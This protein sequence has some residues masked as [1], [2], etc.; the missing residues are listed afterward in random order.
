SNDNGGSVAVVDRAGNKQ[1]L[2]GKY[3]A[4]AGLAWSPKGDEVWF[5]AA[6]TGAR[7]DLRAVTMSGRE[8]VL[9]A[10]SVSVLL[11]DV[12]KDGRV[13]IANTEDRMKLMFR[14]PTDKVERE[15]SWLDWSLLNSLSPDGKYVAFSEAGEG[16]GASYAAY[17]RETNGAPAVLLGKGVGPILSP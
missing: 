14:G 12:A 9:L 7:L 1:T 2:G 17:L 10:S 16:A 5:T 6:R 4:A 3:I 15:L 8:R 13:L 11:E